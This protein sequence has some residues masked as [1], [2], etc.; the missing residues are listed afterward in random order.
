MPNPINPGPLNSAAAQPNSAPF[1]RNRVQLSKPIQTAYSGR[2]S[3]NAPVM[4]APQAAA[5]AARQTAPNT[6]PN[7]LPDTVTVPAPTPNGT[8]TQP[9][10]VPVNPNGTP[11]GAYVTGES[12]NSPRTQQPYNY[13]NIYTH[14]PDAYTNDNRVTQGY[15]GTGGRPMTSPQSIQQAVNRTTNTPTIERLRREYAEKMSGNNPY[16]TGVAGR[17]PVGP[18]A[19]AESPTAEGLRPSMAIS[20]N[21][22]IPN[23]VQDIYGNNV[24]KFSW[25]PTP[26][27]EAGSRGHAFQQ[28][29]LENRQNAL[30]SNLPSNEREYLLNQQAQSIIDN[31]Y[32]GIRSGSSDALR[33]WL[34]N[35]LNSRR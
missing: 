12:F 33:G 5:Q 28:R 1:K 14:F 17:G 27:A 35:P 4:R 22:N 31:I 32:N 26:R 16:T 13:D 23:D 15:E 30:S 24:P 8:T 25:A 19:M 11:N 21:S 34:N 6:A 9:Q 29:E 10:G 3:A 2:T 20:S 7:T 18:D